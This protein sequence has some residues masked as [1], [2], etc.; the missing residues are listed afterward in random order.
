MKRSFTNNSRIVNKLLGKIACKL[1]PI[2]LEVG[3][4]CRLYWISSHETVHQP[5]IGK[6]S[7]YFKACRNGSYSISKWLFKIT[8]TIDL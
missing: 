7:H 2:A 8:T 5:E 1:V 3:P 4:R 6:Q